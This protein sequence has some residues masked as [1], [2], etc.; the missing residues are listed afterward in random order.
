MNVAVR[1]HLYGD[2]CLVVDEIKQTLQTLPAYDTIKIKVLA[3]SHV[4][5]DNTL[6]YTQMFT[7][8]IDQPTI[9]NVSILPTSAGNVYAF[10]ST[11]TVT[12]GIVNATA[13]DYNGSAEI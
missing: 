8:V 7:A 5:G 3:Y 2:N 11:V 4:T 9:T 10:N 6:N 1:A 13:I 12:F